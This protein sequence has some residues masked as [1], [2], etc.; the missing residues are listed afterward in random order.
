MGTYNRRDIGVFQIPGYRDG[1][2]EEL[3]F[4]FGVKGGI[5]LHRLQQHCFR[6]VIPWPI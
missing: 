3:V 5:L 2:D 1:L 4:A 6:T